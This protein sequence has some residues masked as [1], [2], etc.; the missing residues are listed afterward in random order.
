MK[1]EYQLSVVISLIVELQVDL[2]K[3][4][5]INKMNAYNYKI[6]K[7]YLKYSLMKID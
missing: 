5:W 4:K 1:V 2:Y 3:N 6:K 7:K